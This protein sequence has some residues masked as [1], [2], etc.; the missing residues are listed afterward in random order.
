VEEDTCE[1]RAVGTFSPLGSLTLVTPLGSLA[2]YGGVVNE[3]TPL[4]ARIAASVSGFNCSSR[5]R[6]AVVAVFA[7]A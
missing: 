2:P 5:P 4:I 7:Y 3:Y 1:S 6:S